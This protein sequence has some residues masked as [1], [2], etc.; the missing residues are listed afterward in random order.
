[1]QKEK[2]DKHFLNRPIYEG[3]PKAMKL[4]VK[5]NLKYP[6]AALEN[7]VEGTVSLR[8]TINY[9]GNVI[10][11]KVISGIGHGCDEEAIRLVKLFKFIVE[12]NRK[13]RATFH[14]NIQIH[15]RLPKQKVQKNAGQ[16]VQ[17]YYVAKPKKEKE[18]PKQQ[19]GGYGYTITINY[20]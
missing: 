17:Y 16:Q 5:E 10:D 9:K 12:K 1:M 7:R 8:Y 19:E 15:F 18:K 6:K 14:K 3:G 20:S 13:V 4:F 2:K 11:A